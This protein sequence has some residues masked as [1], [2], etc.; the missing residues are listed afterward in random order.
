LEALV[1]CEGMTHVLLEV[2]SHQCIVTFDLDGGTYNG[3]TA[4]VEI[5]VK[6]GETIAN[7]PTP[8]KETDTFGGWFTAKNGLGNEFTSSTQV[9]SNRTVFA[10]WTSTSGNGTNPFKGTWIGTINGGFT[11]KFEAGDNTWNQYING[12]EA[13]RG[14]YTFSG[15][16]V[17]ARVTHAN[18]SAFIDGGENA[19]IAYANLDETTKQNMSETFE[20]TV[21]GNSFIATLFLDPIT[22]TKQ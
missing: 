10:K 3:K 15:N 18:M 5:T 20:F 11:L 6:S 14:T 2:T 4:S 9:T 19:W 17:S 12:S 13:V 22:M 16:T 21:T 8:Q 7:L 1:K